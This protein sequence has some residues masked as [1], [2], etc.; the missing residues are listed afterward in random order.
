LSS[1]LSQAAAAALTSK[2]A[3][4]ADTAGSWAVRQNL[5][6]R[7]RVHTPGE[8]VQ[9]ASLRRGHDGVMEMKEVTVVS[10]FAA[11]LSMVSF[12]PQA[13]MII[14]TKSTAGISTKMYLVTV[15]G[16]VL[17]LIYGFMTMQ[18]AIIGQNIICL[19][20]SSFILTMKL[21]PRDKTAA[22]TAK[23]DPGVGT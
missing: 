20:T 12:L 10:L 15:A 3:A 4:S 18:W 6:W 7:L 21:L 5:N 8:P 22:I 1:F 13:W 11:I 16:F 14:K 23:L 17:W 19:V 9:T 2:S